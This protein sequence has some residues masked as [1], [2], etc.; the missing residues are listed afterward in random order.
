[1]RSSR[2]SLVPQGLLHQ[3]GTLAVFAVSI[4]LL[5]DSQLQ[6]KKPGGGGG[7]PHYV[8]LVD[9]RLRNEEQPYDSPTLESLGLTKF[10]ADLSGG[11]LDEGDF[12]QI[13]PADGDF[14]LR[15][16]MWTVHKQGGAVT[17][18]TFFFTTGGNG[19]HRTDALPAQSIS[20]PLGSTIQIRLDNVA[21]WKEKG[22]GKGTVAGLV[23]V[24]DIDYEP[25]N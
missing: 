15:N 20:T 2:L 16:C 9:D 24:G 19:I 8:R 12:L 3:L 7:T 11:S 6:A 10:S 18:V 5:A 25:E 21:V 1:M 14:K 23:S 13:Y 17:G 4:G 22:K